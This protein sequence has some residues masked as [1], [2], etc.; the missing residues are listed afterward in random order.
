MGKLYYCAKCRRVVK[1][2]NSCSYCGGDDIYELSLG[3]QVSVLN[4]K[5]KGKVLKIKDGNVRVLIK[6]ET[7]EKLIKEYPAEELKKVI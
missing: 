3:A 6:A 2:E 1:D 4:Q 5:I 7:K